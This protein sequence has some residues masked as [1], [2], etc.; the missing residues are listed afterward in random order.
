MEDIKERKC[1]GK[2]FL[3][4]EFGGK[5]KEVDD[6]MKE[7]VKIKEIKK[8]RIKKNRNGERERKK[9]RRNSRK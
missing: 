8:R 4:K 5:A 2:E 3:V 7:R 6:E 1:C 9:L